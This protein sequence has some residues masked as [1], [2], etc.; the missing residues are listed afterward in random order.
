MKLAACVGT[1]VTGK[2]TLPPEPTVVVEVDDVEG[3]MVV[4]AEPP[5]G[6]W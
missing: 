3:G 2:L 5:E 1:G 6:G 4:V